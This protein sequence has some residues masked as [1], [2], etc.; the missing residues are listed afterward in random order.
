VTVVKLGSAQVGEIAKHAQV[1]RE[2]I[3]RAL[4]RLEELGLI[5]KSLDTPVK[6][7]ALPLEEALR[8]LIKSRQ[9]EAAERMSRLNVSADEFLRQYK[10]HIR[11]PQKDDEETALFSL[12][13]GRVPVSIKSSN[14]IKN[15]KKQIDIVQSREGLASFLHENSDLLKKAARNGVTVRIVTERTNEEDALQRLIRQVISS[16]REVIDLRHIDS[17]PGNYM[18]FDAKEALITTSTTPNP[19]E[20]SSLYTRNSGLVKV[21]QRD[22][23]DVWFFASMPQTVIGPE[24]AAKK[25]KRAR[26]PD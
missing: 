4:P 22:F 15:S 10:M 21:L 26:S 1:R 6:I 16:S 18:I 7:H 19:S 9:D 23:G 8:L 11:D 3:Y 17:L 24:T 13:S 20:S 14:L 12:I 2:D 5:E 25:T